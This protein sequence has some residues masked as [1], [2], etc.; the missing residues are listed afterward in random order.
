MQMI[1]GWKLRNVKKTVKETI[2]FKNRNRIRKEIVITEMLDQ[3]N[4][5]S[6]NM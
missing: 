2:E 4:E 6:G 5:R 1:S 3:M